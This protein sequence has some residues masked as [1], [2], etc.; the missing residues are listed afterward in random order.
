M[1]KKI[2]LSM[3]IFLMMSATVYAA[4]TSIY[5]EGP[6]YYTI[7]D[8]SI[9]ITGCFGRDE[10]VKVPSSIAGYPVNVIGKKAFAENT[11][12]KKVELPDTIMKI[13]EGAFGPNISVDYDSALLNSGVQEVPENGT[14]DEAQKNEGES[15]LPDGQTDAQRTDAPGQVHEENEPVNV[16]EAEALIIEGEEKTVSDIGNSIKDE[17]TAETSED[18]ISQ[19][20]A[21][22]AVGESNAPYM[23][24]AV[25]VLVI[26]V[27]GIVIWQRRKK[28]N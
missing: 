12:V 5:S 6:L 15:S 20:E 4:D 24:Y 7:Q 26:A 13:E 10:V 2:L 19:D 22:E 18:E 9:T 25:P 14:T 3:M 17:V 27:I 21:A 16:D 23:I 28:N 8:G 1:I 11:Y